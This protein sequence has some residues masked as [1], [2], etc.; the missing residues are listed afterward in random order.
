MLKFTFNIHTEVLNFLNQN[1]LTILRIIESYPNC[2]TNDLLNLLHENE[3][4]LK[5]TQIYRYIYSLEAYNLIIIQSWIKS[6]KGTGYRYQITENGE[7]LLR[8]LS[9]IFIQ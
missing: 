3:I 9:D 7:K 6:K 2:F 8:E 5:R 4:K 1:S